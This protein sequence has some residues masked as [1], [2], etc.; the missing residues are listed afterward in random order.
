[1]R[2]VLIGRTHGIPLNAAG[3]IEATQLAESLATRNI[4]KILSS[5]LERCRETAD[6]IAARIK[7][8]LEVSDALNEVDFGDWTGKTFDELDATQE[9]KQWNTFR[10]GVRPQGGESML[11]VQHRVVSLMQ[12][13]RDEF[14]DDA[15]ALVSHGDPLRAA[16]VYFLGMPLDFIRRI[17]LS[18]ASISILALDRWQAVLQALN[19]AS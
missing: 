5:P 19:A 7:L 1:M 10:T 18:P 6:P 3:R 16:I 13:L 9:W 4:R 12:E 2:R 15:V 11:D 8:D 17:E 14:H